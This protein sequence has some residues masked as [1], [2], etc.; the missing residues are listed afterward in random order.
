[1]SNESI[2]HCQR[3]VKECSCDMLSFILEK[4]KSSEQELPFKIENKEQQT[5]LHVAAFVGKTDILKL[6][7]EK[8]ACVELQ[9]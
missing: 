4:Y 9:R 6:Y 8:D 3:C 2:L 1:M 7:A 5:P